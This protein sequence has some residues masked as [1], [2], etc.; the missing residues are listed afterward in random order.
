MTRPALRDATHERAPLRRKPRFGA[1]E[2]LS[3]EAKRIFA[4]L[5]ADLEEANPGT[6]SALDV[7]AIA[8]AAQNYATAQAM[9]LAMRA[10]GNKVDALEVDVDHGGQVRKR[11]AWQVYRQA[12]AAYMIL[13]REFGLTVKA[14]QS[15]ELDAGVPLG[16]EDEGDLEDAL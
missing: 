3:V 4:V 6:L 5:V 1:P 16:D 8:L 15:M 2:W 9:S 12:Q 10:K 7:P 11:A 14:R 13:A